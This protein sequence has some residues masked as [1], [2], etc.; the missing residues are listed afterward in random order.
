M[1]RI[2]DEE[3]QRLKKEVL[4]EH[5]AAARNVKLTQSGE[6]LMG[7]CPFHSDKSPSFIVS[8]ETN[9]W[10]CLGACRAGGSVIDFVMRAEG[11]SFRHAVELLRRDA[12][13]AKPIAKVPPTHAVKRVLEPLATDNAGD[14]ELFERVVDHYHA[15]LLEAAEAQ[16]YLRDRGL[17]HPEVMSHFRLG[18]A[19][20]TLGYKLPHSTHKTAAGLRKRLIELGVCR[21]SGHE[22]LSGCLV[23]PLRDAGGQVVQL[24]GRK[25]DNHVGPGVAKHLYLA[26]PQR[27]V[28]NGAGLAGSEEVILCEALID[29]L[30]FWCSGYQQ[31]TSGYGVEGVTEEILDALEAAE[32]RLVK[33]A[34]DRD[35]AGDRG[36][37]RVS[38]RLWKRGIASSRVLFPRGMDANAYALKVMPAQKSLE[39]VLQQAEWMRGEKTAE[40]VL[41]AVSSALSEPEIPFLAA[42]SPPSAPPSLAA[43]TEPHM[44]SDE[45]E[46]RPQ[47]ER[48]GGDLFLTFGDRKWRARN[49]GKQTASELKFNVL[50][51]DEREGGGYFVET[52]DLYSSRQRAHFTKRAALE[53]AQDESGLHR[54][55]AAIVLELE[56]ER[57]T[58]LAAAAE[59]AK[60]SAETMSESERADALALLRD[61]K[62]CQRIVDDLGLAGMVGEEMNKLV[63]YVAATSRKLEAPL[64]IV[65]Q[66]SSAAGKS[67]L[68]DAV[69][70]LMPDEERVQYSAMTGQSLF[71][72]SGQN[73]KHKIL[74]IVEEEGAERASYALKLLQ[75]EGELTIASTGKDPATGRLITQ[76]YRVEGPVMIFL[77]TTSPDVDEELL[78]RCMV[79]SVDERRGQTR[80]IHDRQRE[81][82]TLEGFLARNDRQQIRRLHKNAQRLLVPMMVVNPFARE[83]DFADHATRARRDHMKYLTMIRAVT[84]LHQHQR[85]VQTTV[86]RGRTLEYIESTREDVELATQLAQAVL[87]RSL[88]DL[89]PQ[90]RRLLDLIGEMVQTRMSREKLA[91]AAVRFTRREAR[92][93]TKWGQTQLRLHLERLEEH[94]YVVVHRSGGATRLQFYQLADAGAEGGSL[95]AGPGVTAV[96]RPTMHGSS[97]G[98]GGL[99]G[100]YRPIIAPLSGGHRGGLDVNKSSEKA[101]NRQVG[102]NGSKHA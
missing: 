11:I 99:S 12:V 37:E 95:L 66:S 82:Q 64:A 40:T 91:Q 86:H 68:M 45:Q 17:T 19:N 87:P 29:A 67:S 1:A 30:T 52:L 53:L 97:G 15:A 10:H 85:P 23:V 42:S 3:I 41:D 44:P 83:L 31:V 38:A 27:G 100:V 33:I 59:P 78:N 80:A 54:E 76:T 71:Y 34:F 14:G 94:E 101:A 48:D 77:T 62:L 43:E 21:A 28:F 8:R 70:A 93:W 49:A 47:V 96:G 4:V 18:F 39:L 6:N 90:T 22:H 69:L 9:L 58:E 32:V 60:G 50:V 79:L 102:L 51:S 81:S 2:P 75:S 35:E 7:L 36:A 5:L 63:C 16:A 88:D 92:E 98:E 89:P 13:P 72:M 56:S 46:A 25:I 65:L 84:L 26:S 74:A 57:K 61:P 24:Y 73:L 20:R 55:L